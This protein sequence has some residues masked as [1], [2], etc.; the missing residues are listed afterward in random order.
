MAVPRDS[1]AGE[2]CK[3][4]YLSEL[5]IYELIK[6]GNLPQLESYLKEGLPRYVGQQGYSPLRRAKN[7]FLSMAAKAAVIGA[8]PGG[9]EIEQVYALLDRYAQS[10][11]GIASPDGIFVLEHAML[12]DFCRR[13]G[14]ARKPPG[15]SADI[16]L[17][18]NYI[19]SR[20]CEQVTVEEVAQQVHCSPSFLMRKFK[21]ETGET[22]GEYARR[23]KLEEAKSL[24]TFSEK[25]LSEIADYLGFSSQP[26]FQSVFR[27]YYG[28]TPMEWRKGTRRIL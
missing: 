18:M 9:V 15:V 2:H 27:R 6:R 14:E 24:L 7:H 5:Q 12:L 10:C 20:M 11:E 4:A 23:C 28:V 22:V 3:E 17:C 8:I 26:Y 25:S 19:E 13:A 1:R 21:Q 16:F